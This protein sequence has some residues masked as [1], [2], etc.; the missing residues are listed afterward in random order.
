LAQENR[1]A[2][3]G[4]VRLVRFVNFENVNDFRENEIASRTL[5][6][7]KMLKIKLKIKDVQLRH[8][9]NIFINFTHATVTV[10]L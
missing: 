10:D 7:L 4:N 1:P 2:R 9:L 8:V 6:I 3:F 5:L